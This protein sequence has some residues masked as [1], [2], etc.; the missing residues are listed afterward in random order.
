V[1]IRFGGA[2]NVQHEVAPN[3]TTVFFQ[4]CFDVFAKVQSTTATLK[5]DF[6]G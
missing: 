3:V 5:M 4:R 6:E 1:L 2:L